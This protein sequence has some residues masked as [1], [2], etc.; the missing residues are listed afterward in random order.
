MFFTLFNTIL[1]FGC[2][3]YDTAIEKEPIPN[4]VPVIE[5]VN[6]TPLEPTTSELL[7]CSVTA[8]DED[9]DELTSEFT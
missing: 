5:Q 1:G 7:T 4:S 3:D 8:S 9:N 6:I 2:S